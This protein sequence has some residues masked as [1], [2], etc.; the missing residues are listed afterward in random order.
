VHSVD[1]SHTCYT[2]RSRAG[3]LDYNVPCQ[4]VFLQTSTPFLSFEPT[5]SLPRYVETDPA[6]PDSSSSGH[7]NFGNKNLLHGGYISYKGE[8]KVSTSTAHLVRLLKY[9]R[10]WEENMTPERRSLVSLLPNM[11]ILCG[12]LVWVLVMTIADHSWMGSDFDAITK[13]L[14]EIDHLAQVGNSSSSHWISSDSWN[15]IREWLSRMIG[16]IL[17]PHRPHATWSYDYTDME[18]SFE[19]IYLPPKQ[20]RYRTLTFSRDNDLHNRLGNS[21]NGS[22]RSGITF[23]DIS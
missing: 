14:E 4:S 23:V 12:Q 1:A 17:G 10:F 21:G 13:Q 22:L 7:P 3:T 9:A 8:G 6:L 2:I 18:E 20:K 15:L 19:T 5:S 16:R 11:D